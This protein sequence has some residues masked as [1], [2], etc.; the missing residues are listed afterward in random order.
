MTG[1]PGSSNRVLISSECGP[2]NLLLSMAIYKDTIYYNTWSGQ[3]K[4]FKIGVAGSCETL[5][6]Y[7]ATFNSMTVDKSGTLY[8]ASEDL[9]RYDPVAHDVVDLGTMPFNSMGDLAFYKDK[10]LLAGYDPMDWSTGIYEININNPADSKLYMGTPSF[11]GL[12]SYPVT[13]GN[14]RYFGLSGNGL[15]TTDL[16]ELDLANKTV[17]GNTCS[18]PLDVLD[19]ASSTENGLDNKIAI[20]SL[21]INKSCH[22]PTGSVSIGAMYPGAGAI[23]YTLDN[24]ISNTT[25]LFTNISAGGH[26]IRVDAPGGVCTSDSSFTI[27]PAYELVN[28]IEKINPDNCANVIGRITIDASSLNGNITYTLLNTGLSQP[29]GDFSDLHGGRYDFR[30]SD[31]AGC[32]KDTSIALAENIPVGGCNSVFIPTAFTPNNDSRN[33]QYT[34]TLSTAFKNVTLQIFGRWGNIVCQ[35]KGNTV[36]WDGNYKGAPQPVGVYIYNLSYT[37]QNGLQKISKGT[38][39]LIR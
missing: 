8:M 24:T 35:A 14:N 13:C 2:T 7:G 11:F 30:I 18:L 38:L 29:T 39:T 5:M 10:L 22:F 20:T 36:S 26:R 4:R 21:K 15:G 19:A 9:F 32:S 1:G 23:T 31:E 3:L 37:D 12:L 34:I 27:A 16:F 6:E 28:R 17:I 25:G 33:D